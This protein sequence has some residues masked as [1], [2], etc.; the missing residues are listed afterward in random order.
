MTPRLWLEISTFVAIVVADAFGLVPLTQT[1]LLLPL[2]WISLRLRG[3]RWSSIGFSWPERIG[4]SARPPAL[5]S[6]WSPSS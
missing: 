3:E 1:I 2:V 4:R 6:S 5:H